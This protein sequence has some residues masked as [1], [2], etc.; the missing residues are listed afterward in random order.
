MNLQDVMKRGIYSCVY[1]PNVVVTES[2]MFRLNVDAL[3]CFSSS[4]VHV[5]F[6]L[7]TNSSVVDDAPGSVNALVA[8]NCRLALKSLRG[9]GFLSVVVTCS[10]S[11]QRLYDPIS[12]ATHV[13]LLGIYGEIDS[14]VDDEPQHALSSHLFVKE[15]ELR[16]RNDMEQGK[17]LSLAPG[18]VGSSILCP[19]V[20][21]KYKFFLHSGFSWNRE[22]V[23]DIIGFSTD[24]Q[25]LEEVINLTLFTEG[26]GS[27]L[28][29]SAADGYDGSNKFVQDPKNDEMLKSSSTGL[30]SS[31]DGQET[32]KGAPN[33]FY[34]WRK[35]VSSDSMAGGSA[36]PHN[37]APSISR[38]EFI[39][40]LLTCSDIFSPHESNEERKH[41]RRPIF[42]A[43]EGMRNAVQSPF[44]KKSPAVRPSRAHSGQSETRSRKQTADKD[45][46]YSFSEAE[47]MFWKFLGAKTLK[48][49]VTCGNTRGCDNNS[50]EFES[51]G[52]A[53]S[54]AQAL[55]VLKRYR[56]ALSSVG[57]KLDR[58]KMASLR[59][60]GMSSDTYAA[61][62]QWGAEAITNRQARGKNG[63]FKHYIFILTQN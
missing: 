62:A 14:C 9:A 32:E 42:E 38:S 60:N 55:E 16:C 51:D 2:V 31:L 37:N 58:K 19:L 61:R 11:F 12:I 50:S 30:L 35:Q 57:W 8:R 43:T 17:T 13:G 25:M 10:S 3:R 4:V 20:L 22:T 63:I 40:S 36:S 18:F 23:L 34:F 53:P 29:T 48:E 52:Y 24:I 28:T 41:E 5:D 7:E 15:A 6:F 47:S 27:L 33:G 56:R 46:S 54:K 45:D 1:R 39:M 49:F 59:E 26:N 44:Y 21:L